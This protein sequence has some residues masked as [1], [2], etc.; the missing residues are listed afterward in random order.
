[1]GELTAIRGVRCLV[2]G[3]S[4]FIGTSL[5]RRLLAGG[6]TV[7]APSSRDLDVT[8][9]EEVEECL[10]AHKPE[11]VF[12]LAARGVRSPA[13]TT[14]L[15]AVNAEGAANIS[16]AALK[17][18]CTTRL[19]MAGSSFEYVPRPRPLSEDDEAGGADEYGSSKAE[20]CRQVRD[21]AARL[22]CAWVRP[23][24]VYGPGEP[25][26]RLLPYLADCALNGKTAELTEGLQLRDYMHV[27]DL[28]E[29][30]ER[31]ALMM[32]DG[33]RWEVVNLGSGRN[34]TVREFVELVVASLKA[35]GLSPKVE[36]GRRPS[37][38]QDVAAFIPDLTKMQRLL[39]WIPK[40][41][42]G[43]GIDSTV[44]AI[45]GGGA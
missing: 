34:V 33:P 17:V 15:R 9:R 44:G 21:S 31:A 13:D 8:R 20:G 26:P 7:F 12:H 39:G 19:V 32:G 2:T 40:T 38:S 18:G 30:L 1:M 11:I 45:L 10:A 22:S 16:R 25:L 27:E 42:L 37:R 36:Y 14:T 4:G 6:A 43:R 35:R 3:G 5:R 23:F 24:N 29:C 28:A 41:D